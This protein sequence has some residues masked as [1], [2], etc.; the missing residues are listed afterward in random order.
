[1][2]GP[3]ACGDADFPR[4]AIR[5]RPAGRATRPLRWAAAGYLVRILLFY[6]GARR[7]DLAAAAGGQESSEGARQRGER[8]LI[9]DF[10]LDAAGEPALG[11][12]A[13]A[14]GA[15]PIDLFGALGG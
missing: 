8:P 9:V 5:G 1:M 7:T 14:V 15:C 4:A 11:A 3:A 6:G 13:G 12:L 10:L 2:P